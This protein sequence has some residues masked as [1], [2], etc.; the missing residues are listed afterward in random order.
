MGVDRAGPRAVVGW[1][2][3]GGLALLLGLILLDLLA[4]I[5][6]AKLARRIGYNSEGYLFALVAAAWIQFARPRLSD[7]SRGPLTT[8]AALGCL[9]VGLLLLDSE[10]PS[11]FKTLNEPMIALALVLPYLTLR[12]AVPRAVLLIPPLILLGVIVGLTLDP[13]GLVINLA[14][15]F[16]YWFLVPIVFDLT[17]KAILD[18]AA[19]TSPPTRYLTY[20]VLTVVPVTVSALGMAEREGGGVH[21]GLSYLGRIHESFIGVLLPALYFAVVL[22]RTGLRRSR[23]SREAVSTR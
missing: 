11:R 13:D 3:Y 19:E 20:A 18:P 16:G 22:G 23:Q 6:P 15:T 4:D 8:A 7:R 9:V 5:L 17:D 14:E 2:F 12:R 10:L 21:A 1:I